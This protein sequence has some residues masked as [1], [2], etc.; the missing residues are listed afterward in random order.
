MAETARE[1]TGLIFLLENLGFIINNPK[2]LLT[3]T[4]EIEF[5][6]FTVNTVN[7]E[8]REKIKKIRTET[9]RLQEMQNPQTLDLFRLQWTLVNPDLVNPKPRFTKAQNYWKRVVQWSQ[10]RCTCAGS[11]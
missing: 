4:Q 2:S 9:K 1:H 11:L 3:P 6:G 7:M 8:P 10:G 5:L